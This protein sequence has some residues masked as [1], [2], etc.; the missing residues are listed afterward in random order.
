MTGALVRKL[1]AFKRQ[2]SDRGHD[3]YEVAGEHDELVIAVAL[4]SW[5]A[6][7]GRLL[8]TGCPPWNPTTECPL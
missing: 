2:V 1:Q 4:V 7:E 3:T 6:S 8:A 5:L